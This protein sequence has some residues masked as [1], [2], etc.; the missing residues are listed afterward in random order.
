MS[1]NLQCT[2]LILI[3]GIQEIK[4]VLKKTNSFKATSLLRVISLLASYKKK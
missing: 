1:S 3:V 2:G 4:S